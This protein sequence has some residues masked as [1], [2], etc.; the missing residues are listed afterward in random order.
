MAQGE[1][2]YLLGRGELLAYPVKLTKP[3]GPKN[4][5]YDISEAKIRISQR[6]SSVVQSL[7]SLPNDAKPNNETVALMTVHPR[8]V[9]KSDFPTEL[10]QKVGLR[11]VGSRPRRVKPEKWG[12]IKHP[13]EALTEEIFIAGPQI[14]FERWLNGINAWDDRLAKLLTTIEDIIVPSSGN[15]IRG[16]SAQK[17]SIFLEVVIH[18][19][20]SQ[21]IVSAFEDYARNLGVEVISKRN[22]TIRGLTFVAV[23][24]PFAKITEL[25]E[26]SF[27]RLARGMPTLRPMK[28]NLLR[29]SN[30]FNVTFPAE[31]PID[32]SLTAVIFDGGLPDDVDLSPWVRKIDPP[33]IGDPDPELQ[34]HGLAVTS[35]LLFGPLY[36][37]N[38]LQRPMCNVDH[39]RVL[40]VDS[41]NSTDLEYLDVLDRILNTLRSSPIPYQYVNLSL[42]PDMAVDDDDVTSWTAALDSYFAKGNAIVTVAAGNGGEYTPNDNRIQPPA[43]GVNMFAVGS[44]DREDDKWTRA[45][46]SSIGPGRQPGIVKPDGVAFGGSRKYPFMALST[47]APNL[48]EGIVG[49]SFAAP[50][51]LRA[52]TA[53]GVQ[54]RNDLTPLAL[55][56]LL[57]HKARRDNRPQVE[58]GWGRLELDYERLITCEDYESL[59]VFQGV[60]PVGEHL[61]AAIPVPYTLNRGLVSL[62]A[63]FVIA[64]EVDPQYPG[65]YT[66]SGVEVL[67][68]PH[69]LKY[70]TSPKGGLTSQATTVSFFSVS[71]IF[72]APE[73]ELRDGGHKWEPCMHNMR[74]FRSTSLSEP[75]FDI[76]YNHRAFGAAVQNPEPIPYALIVS[77]ACP[78]DKDFYNKVVRR[79]STILVPLRPAIRIPIQNQI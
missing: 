36:D 74:S 68:R 66:R 44:I 9:S 10:L 3:N 59:V 53:V 43:D 40:D 48:A 31:G 73:Y 30:S 46:Y 39:V 51:T 71:N 79:Y 72:S 64:P 15:K 67:F 16:I 56:A 5:P 12:V 62:A 14:S 27:L 54:L 6:L 13:D 20:N 78:S 47:K 1:N 26:F 65:A 18:N 42:G 17:D 19:D 63:T 77:V 60:L 28:P 49:T 35:A 52:A 57:V 21:R 41:L 7:A 45:S 75:V 2:N 38:P 76:Y 34:A 37:G 69:A 58:V 55:R 22:R 61:R 70:G 11:A 23:H 29:V 50:A 32:S 33:G 25:A 24:A 8:Y 4:P